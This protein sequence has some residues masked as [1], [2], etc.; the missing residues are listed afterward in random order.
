MGAGRGWQ[1][2]HVTPR[3]SVNF[4]ILTIE[5]PKFWG[6]DPPPGIQEVSLTHLEIFSGG[7][8]ARARYFYLKSLLSAV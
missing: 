8:H 1:G 4:L 6:F 5:S 3:D 2:G 7:A